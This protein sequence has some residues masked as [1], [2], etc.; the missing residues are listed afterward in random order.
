MD[1]VARYFEQVAKDEAEEELQKDLAIA[2]DEQK[3]CRKCGRWMSGDDV[4]TGCE[5]K[6]LEMNDRY[7]VFRKV[8]NHADEDTVKEFRESTDS[9]LLAAYKEV[10]DS[11]KLPNGLSWIAVSKRTSTRMQKAVQHL[12]GVDVSDYSIVID[13][14]HLRHIYTEHGPEGRADHSLANAEDVARMKFV[15]DSPDTVSLGLTTGGEV[16]EAKDLNNADG[17]K[18]KTLLVRR[19]VN[20]NFYVSEAVVD[21]KRKQIRITGAYKNHGMDLRELMAKEFAPII[22]PDTHSPKRPV[23]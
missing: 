3:H 19:Q 9:R 18:A 1:A 21:S 2:E 16:R 15:L 17:T 12:I 8:G 13:S 14:T 4:C 5:S 7:M 11:G 10:A 20:G 23:P 22:R 6:V